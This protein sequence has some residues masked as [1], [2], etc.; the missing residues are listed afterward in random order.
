MFS[1]DDDEPAENVLP[2]ANNGSLIDLGDKDCIALELA[3]AMS[4]TDLAV[5]IRYPLCRQPN[6]V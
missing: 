2:L 3:P 6:G 5:P 4:V 1:D